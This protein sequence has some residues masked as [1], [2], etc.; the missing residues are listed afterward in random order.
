MSLRFRKSFKIAPGVRMTV[1]K[2]GVGVSAGVPGLRYSIN[3]SGRRTSTVGIPGSGLSYSKSSGG[4][5][6]KSDAYRKR[7]ELAK[8][9]REMQ[10]LEA[11]EQVRLEVELFNNKLALLTSIHHECDDAIEWLEVAS[12]S[13]PFDSTLPGPLQTE[14]A[15][16]LSAYK[17]GF[18][19]RLFG[20][21]K[22]RRAE[23]VAAVEAAKNEDRETVDR[24]KRMTS[25]A[26]RILQGDIDAYFEVVDEFGPLD[27]LVEFGSGFEFGTDR[28][29][30]M[31]IS[32]D[33]HA[34]E[35]IPEKVLTLTKTGKLSEKNMTKTMYYDLIQD[36]V[37]SCA[38]RIAR[39]MFALLPVKNVYVHAYDENLNHAT[40][41]MEKVLILSV[42]YDRSTMD[43]LNFSLLD[44]SEALANFPHKMSFKKTKGFEEVEP[45][46]S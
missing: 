45:I 19:E 33:V 23:L 35:V 7:S 20:W 11:Q 14:A 2:K 34:T 17:P 8:Q 5:T 44:P 22:K 46:L 16:R 25:I 39:D 24:W 28:P 13:I 32:F 38:L 37:C 21:D 9:E 31:H 42:H 36:Y 4:R 26:K 40:G 10:K 29:D 41:H 18:F 30:E 27:D 12:T 43:M 3:S 1:G 15:A 6:Y